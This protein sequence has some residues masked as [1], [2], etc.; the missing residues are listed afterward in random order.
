MIFSIRLLWIFIIFWVHCVLF[1]C[2][3]VVKVYFQ[4]FIRHYST[5]T[6]KYIPLHPQW[7]TGFTDGEGSFGIKISKA[8]GYKL[9][10]KLQPFFQIKLNVR[11]LDILYRIKEYFGGVGTIGFEKNCAKYTIRKLSDIVDI[12]IPHFEAYPLLTKKFAD[13]ELFRQ[14]ILILKNESSLSEQGFIKILN[15]R[16]YL[17]KGISEE[18]KELYP[19]LVP[20]ARPEVPEREIL[21]EWLVGFA[22]GE[23]SFNVITVEKKSSDASSIPSISYKVWLHFQITQ[24]SRDADLMERIATFFDCGGSVKKR[25]TDVVDFKL[26]KFELLENIIIPFFQKYPLLSIFL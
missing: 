4:T 26:N 15:L 11:D 3:I 1:T 16:Y 5:L 20:V 9:G 6:I 21:P 14:I 12:L 2:Y 24:H 18:L 10:W 19:N 17:N 7:I 13:F 8:K 23:G 25:N 22:D